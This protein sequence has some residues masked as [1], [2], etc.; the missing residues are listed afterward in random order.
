MAQQAKVL[1]TKPDDL[2]SIPGPTWW[3]L[4]IDSSYLLTS[5]SVCGMCPCPCPPIITC[6][7]MFFK[8]SKFVF[9]PWEGQPSVPSSVNLLMGFSVKQT[10]ETWISVCFGE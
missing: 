3:K 1:A 5:T 7:K 6:L 9:S 2:S 8:A 10:A 4:I